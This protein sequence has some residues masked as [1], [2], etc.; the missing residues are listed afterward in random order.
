MMLLSGYDKQI[1]RPTCNSQFK[2]LHCIARLNEDVSAALP[3]LNAELGGTQYLSDP[4]EVMFYHNGRI[5]KVGAKE[6]A[7]NALK[8][9]QEADK[10]LMWL[11]DQINRVWQKRD[12]ITPCREG[13]KRPQLIEILKRLPKTNCRKCG[14]PTCMVFAAQVASGGRGADNCPELAGTERA[15]LQAYLA[16]FVFD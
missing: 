6:I 10:I 3:Y 2:S 13:A 7:I 1:F 12:E 14:Q 11:Q 8:D 15:E 4:P 9:E 5:I 16:P